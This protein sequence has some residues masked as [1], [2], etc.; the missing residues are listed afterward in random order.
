MRSRIWQTKGENLS[1][2]LSRLQKTMSDICKVSDGKK[3]IPK[4]LRNILY[5]GLGQVVYGDGEI[6]P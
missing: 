4:Y 3:V 2:G 5:L 6:Y 1:V